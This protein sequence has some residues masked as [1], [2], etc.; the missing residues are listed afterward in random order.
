MD[1]MQDEPI[2]S[3]KS[4]TAALAVNKVETKD[5]TSPQKHS[6]RELNMTNNSSGLGASLSPNSPEYSQSNH[7]NIGGNNSGNSSSSS[8]SSSSSF[9][10]PNSGPSTPSPMA[11]EATNVNN[12]VSSSSSSS[13][14]N[15]NA[16]VFTSKTANRQSS[17]E[18][19]M[20]SN[21]LMKKNISYDCLNDVNNNNV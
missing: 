20:H 10:A 2:L 19:D 7:N 15:V 12:S 3:A 9:S 18:M 1:E 21:E 13:K 11:L 5:S 17:V 8:S 16:P 6:Q 14:I 4:T